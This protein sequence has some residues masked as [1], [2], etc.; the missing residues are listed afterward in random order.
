MTNSPRQGLKNLQRIA[1]AGGALAMTAG[2]LMAA[3]AL[4][5]AYGQDQGYGQT[6]QG[7]AQTGYG[8]QTYGQTG[9][10]APGSD[11]QP[12]GPQGPEAGVPGGKG[13]GGGRRRRFGN[14][15]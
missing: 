10:A 6:Q 3:P 11:Q 8:Q 12:P 14:L 2:P 13:G 5:Q 15:S 4:A 1:L 9:Y 7:Y